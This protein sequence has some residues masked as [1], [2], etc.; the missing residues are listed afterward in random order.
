MA[1]RWRRGTPGWRPRRAELYG[2]LP[3]H[4]VTLWPEEVTLVTGYAVVPYLLSLH[5]KK[6]PS[7]IR[8]INDVDQKGTKLIDV[9]AETY[10]GVK[11]HKLV[12]PKETTRSLTITELHRG[13]RAIF[14]HVRPGRSGITSS[15]EGPSGAYN[16]T[17][18]DREHLWLRQALIFPSGG[19]YA[20]LL[21]E[22]VANIGTSSMTNLLLAP[23]LARAFPGLQP[24]M[25]AAMDED[26]LRDVIKAQPVAK[27]T[28][29]RPR[30]G[31]K[32]GAFLMVNGKSVS[33]DLVIKPPR[34]QSWTLGSLA[35]GDKDLPE[36][37]DMMGILLPILRP[38]V[39]DSDAVRAE[40]LDE[41]WEPSLETRRGGSRKTLQVGT[42]TAR[43]MSLMIT[44]DDGNPLQDTPDDEQFRKACISALELFAGRFGLPSDPG[45][46]CQWDAAEWAPTGSPREVRWNDTPVATAPSSA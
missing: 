24:S 22:R 8:P 42:T 5:V 44:G 16:R 21:S 26:V 43:D 36:L 29:R 46:L 32:D 38:G 34:K 18:Q 15:I 33:L 4:P 17:A 14:A 45:P 39:E 27:M 23:N 1:D 37:N 19:K 41:G 10:F 30:R 13:D 3:V 20:F 35:G 40:L 31:D 6:S 25:V 9:I 7:D 28:F 2:F 11:D 12:H